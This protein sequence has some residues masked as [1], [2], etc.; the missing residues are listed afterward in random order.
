MTSC[1]QRQ[2]NTGKVPGWRPR[3]HKTKSNVDPGIKK[4]KKTF[5][6]KLMK[7]V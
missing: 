5:M 1:C 6:E 2:G 4:I 7:S 3:K